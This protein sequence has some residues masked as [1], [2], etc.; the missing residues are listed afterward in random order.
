MIGTGA[1]PLLRWSLPQHLDADRI[2]VGVRGGERVHGRFMSLLYVSGDLPPTATSFRI[3]AGVLS[4]GERYVF[5][6]MLEE[7]EGGMLANRSLNFS[8]PYVA[9][10]RKDP[11]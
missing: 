1:Q 3:P 8:E 10:R 4:E 11:R 6:V 5:Q 7:L 2:R 9:A